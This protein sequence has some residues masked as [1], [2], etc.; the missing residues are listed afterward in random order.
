VKGI[1]EKEREV[2]AAIDASFQF[3]EKMAHQVSKKEKENYQL[4]Q[5]RKATALV[6][7]HL[8]AISGELENVKLKDVPEELRLKLYNVLHT[9]EEAFQRMAVYVVL[10]RPEEELLLGSRVTRFIKH[11]A[12]LK[13]HNLPD[14]FQYKSQ[15]ERAIQ[16]L[17]RTQ[18]LLETGINRLHEIE[19]VP[20]FRSYSLLKTLLVLHPVHWWRNTKLLFRLNTFT[21][22]YAL[23]SA[24][25]AAAA[26]FLSKWLD[27]DYGHWIPFTVLLVV[28]P[29]FGATLKRAIDRVVGTI[30]GGIFA[31][32]LIRIPVGVYAHEIMLFISSVCMVYF[33]SKRYSVAAFFITVSLVLLF[34][35]EAEADYSIIMSR[36]LSTTAGAALGIAAGFVLLPSW[37]RKWLPIHLTNAIHCNYQYFLAS[38]FTE[39]TLNWTKNKR[40]AE[41]KNSNVF[42]SFIRYMQ[43]PAIR[44]RPYIAFYQAI[45]HNVRITREINNIHLEQESRNIEE[46]RAT[47]DQQSKINECLFWFEKNLE[48]IKRLNPESHAT[49]FTLIK[50]YRSPFELSLHQMLYLDKL[51]FELKALNHALKDLNEQGMQE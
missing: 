39:K 29:Y 12:L 1:Y 24:V 38:F 26:M 49:D 35:V 50:N 17:E 6:A 19:D 37:D 43:E 11:L 51:L 31:G 3:Y 47:D 20:V 9:L 28:Q 33:I 13:E 44:Q 4:A 40:S 10:L 41:S 8:E 5:L 45:T 22:R 14:D 7:T 2:R 16:L 32:L 18:R 42:D 25:A 34:E 36:A 30:A 23:R 46:T 27:I 48:E 15:F 21:T